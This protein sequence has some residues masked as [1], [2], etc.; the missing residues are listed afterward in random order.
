LVEFFASVLPQRFFFAKS[1]GYPLYS[2][3]FEAVYQI[4]QIMTRI[5]L[6]FS[7]LLLSSLSVFA[8]S[9]A[10]PLKGIIYKRETAYN[11][12]VSTN[13]GLIFGVEKGKLRAYDLTTFYHL[14]LGEIH[15]P[16]E[17]R[18]SAPPQTR[19]RSF[20]YGKQNSLFALRAGW[21]KKKYFSEKAKVKGVAVGM[22]YSLGPTLG[23]LKPYY[24]ALTRFNPDNPLNYSIRF[25]KYSENNADVFL[26]NSRILGAAPFTKGLTEIG[27]LPG[28]NAS[29]AFQL[30]WG[31][32][33][34]RVRALQLGVMLDV[35]P[36]NTPLLVGERNTPLFFNFFAN[37]QFGKRS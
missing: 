27:L 28:A 30:D 22:S 19:Y 8:Q 17:V 3:I 7:F 35:F 37:L 33:D 25:E 24:L 15:H 20:V 18:Q 2:L 11:L 32:F 1:G 14:S 12:K 5:P 16:K 31:A 13:R 6:L 4:T 10:K 23:L 36:N 29:L 21:G 34:Q 26:S 9:T